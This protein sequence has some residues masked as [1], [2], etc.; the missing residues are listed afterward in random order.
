MTFVKYTIL[1]RY[2]PDLTSSQGKQRYT[3]CHTGYVSPH[4]LSRFEDIWFWKKKKNF[5]FF[6]RNVSHSLNLRLRAYKKILCLY[7][8]KLR[9]I[10]SALKSKLHDHLNRDV[11]WSKMRYKYLLFFSLKK[12]QIYTLLSNDVPSCIFTVVKISLDQFYRSY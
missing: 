9:H 7:S 11:K 6:Q 4:F 1:Q 10:Q 2:F 3:T 8:R 12:I 5:F